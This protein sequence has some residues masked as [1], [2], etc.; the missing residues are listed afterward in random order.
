MKQ[1]LKSRGVEIRSAERVVGFESDGRQLKRVQTDLGHYP[2][3]EVILA[4]GAWSPNLA[5]RLGLKLPVEAGKGYRINVNRETG[6]KM[7]A[8]LVE[9]KVAVTPMEGFTRFAGTME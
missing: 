2:A 5:K 6:I 1:Y 7:P 9:S 4:A 3:D 8:I